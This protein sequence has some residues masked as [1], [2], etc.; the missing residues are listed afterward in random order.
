MNTTKRH[1]ELVSWSTYTL[2]NGFRTKFGMTQ[3]CDTPLLTK[4]RDQ[5]VRFLL[6]YVG[7]TAS[8]VINL[9]LNVSNATPSQ[10]GAQ[11]SMYW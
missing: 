9:H 10:E 3:G 2:G 6:S 8:Q 7:F 1:P 4:E 11:A 5:G